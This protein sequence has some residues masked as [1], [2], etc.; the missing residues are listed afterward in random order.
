MSSNP[1]HFVLIVISTYV[2]ERFDRNAYIIKTIKA[3]AHGRFI[4]FKIILTKQNAEDKF[5]GSLFR[6]QWNVHPSWFDSKTNS[7]G[8]KFTVS[9]LS[10]IVG[11]V[12]ILLFHIYHFIFE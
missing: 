5:A 2:R 11:S 9:F 4:R 8:F 3:N 6:P 7:A 1:A 10:D 12:F